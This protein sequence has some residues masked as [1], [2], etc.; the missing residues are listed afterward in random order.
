[1]KMLPDYIDQTT[2]NAERKLFRLFRDAE[3]MD[4]WYCLHSFGISK[5]ISKREGEIDFLFIGPD[6]IFVIE[7]K[8]GR[9]QRENGSWKFTDRYGRITQKKE[10]PF[11]Q[12]RTALYSLRADLVQKFGDQIHKYVFGYGVA[13]PDITFTT[14]S[15]EWDRAM[16][17]DSRNLGN[18]FSDFMSGIGTYWRSRQRGGKYLDKKAVKELVNYL[19][20][21]FETIRPVNL[22]IQDSEEGI[23]RL[24]E[25]QYGALDAME[26]NDRTIFSGPA[27]TGKTLLAVEKARRNNEHGIKTLFLCFNRLLGAHLE[28]VAAREQLT[29]VKVDSLHHFFHDTIIN[30][31]YGGELER[32]E[33]ED[34]AKLFTEAYP[35]LFLR[36]WNKDNEYQELIID[37]GQD[38]LTAGYITALDE[39]LSG[40]FKSGHWTLFMDP[41]TQKDMFVSFDEEVYRELKGLGASYRLTVNCRNTKPIAIQAEVISGYP[42]GQVKKVEGLPVRYLWYESA[43]DQA[44]Q[45][46]DCVNQLLADGV[47]PDDITILSAKRYQASIAGSGRLRLKAGHYQLGHTRPSRHKNLIACGTIQSYKGLESSVIILTDIE[48][49]ASGDMKTVNYVGYTR[50]RTALR[51]SITQKLKKEY[52]EHFAKIAAS[53]G[54]K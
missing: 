18:P 20:G 45:V 17:F 22:D 40:G 49:I 47:S 29:S 54:A 39:T 11:S 16:V 7:V 2:S 42:L 6:G 24:T 50:A 38:I 8:G 37:E 48:D 31:G 43:I 27:G 19:R 51:V 52:K 30:A 34:P 46:S 4:D 41:E 23:L 28:E 35:E 25:E 53:E 21:D 33:R 14:E 15:P 1:M 26:E 36:A 5:H 9:V 12:A 32:K 13:F 3:G 44:R 10:S